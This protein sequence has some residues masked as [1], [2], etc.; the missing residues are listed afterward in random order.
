MPKCISDSDV[1]HPWNFPSEE[2]TTQSPLM[3]GRELRLL[4]LSGVWSVCICIFGTFPEYARGTGPRSGQSRNGS[5]AARPCFRR[6]GRGAN[7]FGRARH[8]IRFSICQRFA[9]EYQEGAAGAICELNRFRGTVNIDFGE[10]IGQ[11]ELYFHA[12]ALWQGGGN[13]G[14]YLEFLTSPSGMSSEN[15]C[16]L[17]SW[18]IEK[19]WLDGRITARVG[20]FAGQVRVGQ[21]IHRQRVLRSSLDAR[22]GGPSYAD[23]LSL[24]EID[25]DGR[26]PVAFFTKPN[27]P[28][29]TSPALTLFPLPRGTAATRPASMI[30]RRSRKPQ[31]RPG[32]NPSRPCW[33]FRCLASTAPDLMPIRRAHEPSEHVLSRR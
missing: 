28:G 21:S 2:I 31:F 26:C 32:A 15:T 22:D 3:Y 5:G 13:L 14:T 6:V 29:T 23:P 9:L 33:R 25:G 8:Q 24:C 20:Q 12:T 30:L 27:R 7:S 10:L 1:T 11:Q 17:D 4:F 18:W 16:R 19:R